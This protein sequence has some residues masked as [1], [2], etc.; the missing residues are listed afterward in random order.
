MIASHESKNSVSSWC[1]RLTEFEDL[2]LGVGDVLPRT[3]GTPC[4]V[5]IDHVSCPNHEPIGFSEH[6]ISKLDH[7]LV[8]AHDVP[9][10]HVGDLNDVNIFEGVWKLPGHILGLFSV[11]HPRGLEVLILR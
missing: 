6:P 2:G 11:D 5:G 9:K 3:A 8:L 4:G 7:A 10:L 1:P